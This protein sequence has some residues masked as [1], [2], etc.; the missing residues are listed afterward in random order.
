MWVLL[1]S[2]INGCIYTEESTAQTNFVCSQDSDCIIKTNGVNCAIASHKNDISEYKPRMP[3]SMTAC[4][5]EEMV[6]PY[7]RQGECQIKYDCSKCD[8]LKER[9]SFCDEDTGGPTAS[10][11]CWMYKNCN[12]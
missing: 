11:I 6:L 8:I 3:P 10:W 1:F 9:L 4:P 5:E 2:I 7:C 12:C